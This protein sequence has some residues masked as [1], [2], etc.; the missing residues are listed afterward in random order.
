MNLGCHA[1][2]VHGMHGHPELGRYCQYRTGSLELKWL[3][4]RA[5]TQLGVG[6]TCKLFQ[7]AM[8]LDT[9]LKV[10]LY[11]PKTVVLSSYN[12]SNTKYLS[13][14]FRVALGLN[15]YIS[16]SCFIGPLPRDTFSQKSSNS[17]GELYSDTSNRF[18]FSFLPPCGPASIVQNVPV[19][20]A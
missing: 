17:L 12:I 9:N 7:S 8:F 13:V 16:V 2:V 1:S 18:R 14:F 20:L 19:C 10:N 15:G 11:N 6:L 3:L 5:I 4:R